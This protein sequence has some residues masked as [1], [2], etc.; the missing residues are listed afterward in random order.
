MVD[1]LYEIIEFFRTDEECYVTLQPYNIIKY[2]DH[3][4]SYEVG[5]KNEKYIVKK[6]LEIECLPFHI[7]L[8]QNDKIFFKK[9]KLICQ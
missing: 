8:V 6:I 3:F 2:N 5:K 9:R 1:A 4:K 7:Y